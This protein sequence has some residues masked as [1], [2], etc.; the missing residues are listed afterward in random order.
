MTN[1]LAKADI[2]IDGKTIMSDVPATFLLSMENQLK[3]LRKVYNT[4]PTYAPG[5]HW[6]VAA[7]KGPGIY[8]T[9]FPEERF[10]TETVTEP[11][12]L[13]P[14]KFPKEGEKGEPLAAQISTTSKTRNVGMYTTTKWTGRFS[15]TEKSEMLGRIDKLLVAVK[16][17]R[18]RA[19]NT[20]IIN[21][22]DS[23]KMLDFIHGVE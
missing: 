21:R 12:V 11:I 9:E 15:P 5:V 14:H 1:Q 6:K 23:K 20:E 22:N 17:A 10:Q 19:N 18:T 4:I 16:K 13:Y 7:D 2:V 8:E 3:E